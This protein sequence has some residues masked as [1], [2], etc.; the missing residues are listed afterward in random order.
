MRFEG[1]VVGCKRHTGL[2]VA[3]SEPI[4]CVE[5]KLV[6]ASALELDTEMEC[7]ACR[8]ESG[9]ARVRATYRAPGCPHDLRNARQIFARPGGIEERGQTPTIRAHWAI[10]S[11]GN[12]LNRRIQSLRSVLDR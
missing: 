3:E 4:G 6:L 10:E 1:N 8:I 7:R 9:S 12:F 11:D 5:L 2:R